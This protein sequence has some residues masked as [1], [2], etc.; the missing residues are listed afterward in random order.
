MVKE[1]KRLLRQRYNSNQLFKGSEAYKQADSKHRNQASGLKLLTCKNG[2]VL[3]ST[4][5]PRPFCIFISTLK[6][7]NQAFHITIT[8]KGKDIAYLDFMHFPLQMPQLESHVTIKTNTPGFL[9]KWLNFTVLSTL[10]KKHSPHN[11]KQHHRKDTLINFPCDYFA[12]LYQNENVHKLQFL[13]EFWGW[14]KLAPGSRIL[15][16]RTKSRNIVSRKRERFFQ[17]TIESLI[18]FTRERMHE[19][20]NEKN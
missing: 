4:S 20:Y 17:K 18:S 9:F 11:I 5:V 19:M 16:N 2:Q 12:R 13:E 7:S 14:K 6:L 1:N 3:N 15:F 8:K 10:I